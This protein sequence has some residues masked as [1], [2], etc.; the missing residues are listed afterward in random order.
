MQRGKYLRLEANKICLAKEGDVQQAVSVFRRSSHIQIHSQ[1]SNPFR[2]LIR[3]RSQISDHRVRN[4]YVKQFCLWYLS[5]VVNR[6]F[7]IE[8]RA[9]ICPLVARASSPRCISSRLRRAP[10]RTLCLSSLE[11]S[12]GHTS[13]T[14]SWPQTKV[15]PGAHHAKGVI[16]APR[17]S[18]S[19][20]VEGIGGIC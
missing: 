9:K 7:A 13:D 19:P 10:W 2:D 6:P 20:R 11:Q 15:S 17:T 14:L 16:D 4:L 8:P 5:H 12:Y 18:A 1:T 3:N